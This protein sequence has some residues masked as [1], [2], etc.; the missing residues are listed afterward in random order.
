MVA[1]GFGLRATVSESVED[2]KGCIRYWVIRN[3]LIF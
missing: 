3:R 2:L 1:H